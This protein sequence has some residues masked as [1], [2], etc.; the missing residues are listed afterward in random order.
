MK[1]R[2][3]RWVII[4]WLI[5]LSF[6]FLCAQEYVIGEEDILYIQFWQQPDLNTRVK[7]GQDG[8]I[9]LP[10][11]GSVTATGL[12]PT[13]LA[14][15]IVEKISIYNKGITQATV[16]VT[17]YGSKKVYLT[18][19]IL[20]PGKYTFETIPNLWQAILEA[21]GPTES[22][23]LS[24]VT[25]IRGEGE[26]P[27]FVDLTRFLESGDSSLLPSL[28]S[29]D[30]IYIPG[31]SVGGG[32]IELGGKR[33]YLYGEVTRPGGYTIEKNLSLLAAIVMAGGPTANAKLSEVTVVSQ[34]IPY[35][36]VATV[37]LEEYPS[38]VPTPFLLRPGDT[39]FVPRKSTF[40]RGFWGTTMDAIGVLGTLSGIYLLVDRL[41]E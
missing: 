15:K 33:V 9:A 22:A 31:I 5:P 20:A 16:V 40:W 38:G 14:K 23:I 11:I 41:S 19:Q 18:G 28:K 36:R 26:K 3:T 7:V 4:L 32:S 37:N 39:I 1:C 13:Q 12:T 24:E 34:G 27:I 30:T 6:H 35:S 25:I 21:G 29:G 17:E 10:I 8:K 2:Y